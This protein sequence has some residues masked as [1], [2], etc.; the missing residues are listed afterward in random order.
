M[1][2]ASFAWFAKYLAIRF[3]VCEAVVFLVVGGYLGLAHPMLLRGFFGLLTIIYCVCLAWKKGRIK[4]WSH[5]GCAIL[6]LMLLVTFLVGVVSLA[7]QLAGLSTAW[8]VDTTWALF[9]FLG[10]LAPAV[11]H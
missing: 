9:G 1:K 2:E 4:L 7:A 10:L 3:L 8:L 5:P 6:L 11:Y